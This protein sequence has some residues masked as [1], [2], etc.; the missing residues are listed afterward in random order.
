MNYEEDASARAINA[1]PWDPPPGLTK[2]RCEECFYW[3]AAQSGAN[4][5]LDCMLMLARVARRRAQQEV[6]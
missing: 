4:R 5:C 3:F 2:R 1:Q 6:R